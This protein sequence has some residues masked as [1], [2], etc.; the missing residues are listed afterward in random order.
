MMR[1]IKV[2][3]KK[4]QYKI[5][6]LDAL[7]QNITSKKIWMEVGLLFQQTKE[8]KIIFAQI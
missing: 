5:V 8:L 7:I 6:I 3:K 1:E 2:L 4:N